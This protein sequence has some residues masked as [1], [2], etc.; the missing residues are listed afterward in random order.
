MKTWLKIALILTFIIVVSI[1]VGFV[2]K[3][4]NETVM[5]VPVIP[6]PPKGENIFLTGDEL[7]E[8][9]VSEGLIFQGQTFGELNVEKIEAYIKSMGEVR[10]AKVYTQIGPEWSIH[11]ELRK[12][13]A[14]IF[15]KYGE[16]YYL[17]SEGHTLSPGGMHTA[18]VLVVTGE[19]PDKLNSPTVQEL[20]NN[21]SL[22]SIRKLD[23][24]YRI[25]NYVCNDPFLL[26]QVAQINYNKYGEFVLIPQ[27]GGHTIVFGS[28]LSDEEVSEK[29]TKL[30]TFY[31]YGM[32]YEG[33][34]K[35]EKI[36]LKYDG[37]IV[38]KKK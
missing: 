10:D 8:R 5:N 20:I 13:I 29:F 11:V 26:A 2:Y 22:K 4:Q 35:Y 25:T 30:K 38:C 31:K 27:V 14:R 3:A 7:M 15:N 12:P 17:D 9:L 19:I 36:V 33:W 16:S 6:I 34:D 21:D 18:R 1:S 32:P 23:D 24:V 37:Q 28:A